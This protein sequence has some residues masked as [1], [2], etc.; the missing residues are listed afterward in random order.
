[1][2]EATQRSPRAVFAI[3][4]LFF[5][6]AT[7]VQ[8]IVPIDFGPDEPFHI[9]SVYDIASNG[10]IPRL[11][12]ETGEKNH[13][14]QHPPTYYAALSL[15]WKISGATERPLSVTRGIVSF[16]KHEPRAVTARRM[17]RTVSAILCCVMLWFIA[18]TLAL[19]QIPPAWQIVLM[20]GAASWPMLQYMSGVVNNESLAYAYSAL[21]CYF[22]VARWQAGSCTPKQALIL[23]LLCGGG[24]LMKQNTLFAV[25][26]ALWVI[27]LAAKPRKASLAAFLGGATLSGMW[28]PLHNILSVGEPFPTY[29]PNPTQPTLAILIRDWRVV[30][31][32]WLRVLLE[33][34]FVPD[35]SWYFVK[36]EFE[37]WI[38]LFV[39]QAFLLLFLLGKGQPQAN[40]GRQSL[41]KALL[42]LLTLALLIFNAALTYQNKFRNDWLSQ[43]KDIIT[44]TALLYVVGSIAALWWNLKRA[45][46]C[47]TIGAK[48]RQLASLS[49]GAMVLLLLGVLHYCMFKDQRA[50]IGGRYLL[51]A[52][53]W[54]VVFLAASLP[55]VARQ[56]NEET[57]TAS[58]APPGLPALIGLGFIIMVDIAWWFLAWTYY[59]TMIALELQRRASGG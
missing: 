34:S 7:L 45:A 10:R 50:Q 8:F 28:W 35:W 14:A 13:I 19:L 27:W 53:P 23:G 26:V 54:A 47:E 38:V 15:I 24:A 30:L 37:S 41:H 40:S 12:L 55:L 4:M 32:E 56:K 17:M 21:L 44:T 18:R 58:L 20:T 11:N 6:I 51:N 1:M 39:S 43:N 22:I 57:G 42:L 2:N 25:P 48:R 59:D 36:R 3:I 49:F 46:R 29:T 9:E 33:T 52:L 16:D 31:Q 5:C